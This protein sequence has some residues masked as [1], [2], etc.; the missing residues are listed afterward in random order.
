MNLE[1][2]EDGMISRMSVLMFLRTTEQNILV[3]KVNA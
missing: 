2:Q 1:K 3:V